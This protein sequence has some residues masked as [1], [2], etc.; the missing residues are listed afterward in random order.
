MIPLGDTGTPQGQRFPIVNVTLIVI[1][2]IIF[3]IQ[4]SVGDPINNGW[5]LIPRE[6]TTGVDLTGLQQLPDGSTIQLYAAPLNNVY[7]T[8]LTSMFMHG[9]WLHIGGNMLFLF[10][11]GDNVEENFGSLKYLVFYLICGFAADITQIF[12]GGPDS[13]IPNLGASGAIAGVLAAYI[14]LFPKARV[15]ALIFLGILVT[16]SY[17]P[18]FIMIGIWIVTQVVS[19]FSVGEVQG[20]GTAFFAHI[21]GFIAGLILVFFFRSRNQSAAVFSR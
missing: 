9:G 18:A 8:L 15:R 3:L 1:N 6:I 11:F 21:G 5:A 14:V 16:I 4:L 13:L 17:V 12:L 19:V 10:I 20:G 2:V 7:L